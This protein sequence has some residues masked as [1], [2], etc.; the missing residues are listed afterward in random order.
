MSWLAAVAGALKA[1]AAW[2]GMKDRAEAKKA[3]QVE[4]QN[5][6][7]TATLDKKKEM[8]DANAAGPRDA[9]D[10]DSRLRGGTF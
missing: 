4:Q 2:I 1:L 10:V 8:D 7:L 3:G 9:D 5:A 6:T